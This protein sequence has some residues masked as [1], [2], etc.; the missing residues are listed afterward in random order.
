[1]MSCFTDLRVHPDVVKYRPTVNDP[2]ITACVTDLKS[3]LDM[4]DQEEAARGLN[5]GFRYQHAVVYDLMEEMFTWIECDNEAACKQF[6]QQ[7][8]IEEKQMT[9]GDFV[10]AILKISAVTKEWM[11]VA[12]YIGKY[13]LLRKFTEIDRLI[14]KYVCTTQSLYV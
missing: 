7:T 4:Y 6:I 9:S 1:M 12:D 10:K 8:I 14:L 3:R 5:T 13:R 2:R 11:N